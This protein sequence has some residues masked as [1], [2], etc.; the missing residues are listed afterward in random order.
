MQPIVAPFDTPAQLNAFVVETVHHRIKAELARRLNID[1]AHIEQ[2]Y[3]TVQPDIDPVVAQV[4]STFFR[5]FASE[6]HLTFD[7]PSFEAAWQIMKVALAGAIDGASQ[8]LKG[9]L[10][11]FQGI[12]KGVSSDPFLGTNAPPGCIR[13]CSAPSALHWMNERVMTVELPSQDEAEPAV[14]PYV[15]VELAS[16]DCKILYPLTFDTGADRL[17]QI[18][19]DACV[20]LFD[21]TIA[22]A[23]CLSLHLP[24]ELGLKEPGKVYQEDSSQEDSGQEGL[25]PALDPQDFPRSTSSSSSSSPP[26]RPPPTRKAIKRTAA[27]SPLGRGR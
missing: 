9:L 23:G 18:S 14:I 27:K 22:K 24:S 17:L 6:T 13:T 26:R 3:G 4:L 7:G 8:R 5:R 1:I 15:F 11:D 10:V 2:V 12:V 21:D 25:P 20:A 19:N 16:D